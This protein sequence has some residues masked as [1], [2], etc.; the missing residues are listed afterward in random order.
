MSEQKIVFNEKENSKIRI[1]LTY[2]YFEEFDAYTASMLQESIENILY[3][4]EKEKLS[5][6]KAFEKQAKKLDKERNKNAIKFLTEGLNINSHT[7]TKI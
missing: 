3:S 7:P 5:F 4:M 6:L 1:D 2:D